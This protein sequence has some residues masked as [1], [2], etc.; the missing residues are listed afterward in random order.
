MLLLLL[1]LSAAPAYGQDYAYSPFWWNLG[2]GYGNVSISNDHHSSDYYDAFH[3]GFSG[4][5]VVDPALLLGVEVSGWIIESE[6]EDDWDHDEWD[7]HDGDHD[8]GQGLSHF[9]IVGILRPADT[10][11]S[12]SGGFG[13]ATY[14]D[15]SYYE[16]YHGH[17]WSMSLGA[18]YSFMTPIGLAL[19]PAVSYT[20]GRLRDD[21]RYEDNDGRSFDILTFKVGLSYSGTTAG[22]RPRDRDYPDRRHP[23]YYR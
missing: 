23:R 1:S 18:G 8:D 13:Y 16:D 3:I 4:G 7:H 15:D 12:L 10:N 14:W 21:N 22:S 17:G 5:V 2:M 11:L 9:Q 20:Y 6:E 19:T